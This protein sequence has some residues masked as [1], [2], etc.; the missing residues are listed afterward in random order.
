MSLSTVAFAR[1]GDAANSYSTLKTLDGV[2]QGPVTTDWPQSGFD[3]KTIRV[4][5]RVTASGH[6]TVH[7]M[8]EAGLPETPNFIGDITIF[9]LV[10]NHL[11][12]EHFCDADNQPRME[13]IPSSDPTTVSFDFVGITGNMQ[14]GYIHDVAFKTVTPDHHI[15]DWTYI[16]PGNK[17]VHV[18]VDL[19]RT[20]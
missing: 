19:Q 18:H 1:A 14:L 9:Y 12:A 20:K 15:E 2:W 6:A 13:A 4:K 17:S 3:G 10:G 7:E 8:R 16:F 5:L 11:M